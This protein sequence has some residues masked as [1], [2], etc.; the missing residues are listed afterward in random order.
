M[1]P[2][3]AS[4]GRW[5]IVGLTISV[6]T[7]CAGSRYVESRHPAVGAAY[8]PYLRG[9][10]LERSAQL[11]DALDAYR[12]ALEHDFQSPLLHVRIGATQLKIGRPDQALRSFQRALSMD[13]SNRD[14]LRWL[15]M[16]HT[17]QGRLPD[18]VKAY[19]QLAQQNPTDTFVLSTLADLYVMQDDL[20]H[21]I[22]L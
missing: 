3:A 2:Q 12:E 21:A 10:M 22:E 6:V 17:S 13:P 1:S 19:E 5:I 14:S 8:G 15:A 9:L 18:A 16:L 4:S 7:G 20:P 11:P